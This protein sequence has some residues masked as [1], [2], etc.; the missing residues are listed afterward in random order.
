MTPIPSLRAPAPWRTTEPR[1]AI[2]ERVVLRTR[3]RRDL[4]GSTSTFSR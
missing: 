4:P 2:G 1:A 3:G